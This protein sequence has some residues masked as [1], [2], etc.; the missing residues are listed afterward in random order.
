MNGARQNDPLCLREVTVSYAA[1]WRGRRRV[2]L[3]GVSLTA[4][5]G[6]LVAIIGPNGSGKSTLLK[7]AAGLLAPARGLRHRGGDHPEHIGYLPE[8]GELPAGLGAGELLTALARI[9]GLG[10]PA[11]EREAKQVLGRVGLSAVANQTHASFSRGQRQRLALAQA[12]LG[13]PDLLLLDEPAAGLDPH[14]M[15]MLEGILRQERERGAAIVFTTHFLPRLE[16][17]CDECLL[18]VEGRCRFHGD[19]AALAARGGA[20]RI[21]LAEVAA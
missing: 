20:E 21:F 14:G 11:A 16:E 3:D 18:L 15:V 4:G 17:L 9:Q 5:R 6:R 2:A 8:H 13:A 7:V 12:L 1:D 10:R 19:A